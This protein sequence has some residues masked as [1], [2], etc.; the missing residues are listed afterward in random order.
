MVRLRDCRVTGLAE[1]FGRIRALAREAGVE[2]RRSELI[3]LAPEAALDGESAR[4]LRLLDYDPARHSLERRLEA[5][6]VVLS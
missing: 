3:G 2:V 4:E 5:R 1:V 6:G